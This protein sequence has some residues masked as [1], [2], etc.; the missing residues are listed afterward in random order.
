MQHRRGAE[1]ADE[2]IP[3]AHGECRLADS[4]VFPI[5]EGND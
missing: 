2:E 1:F 5:S 3:A 4:I